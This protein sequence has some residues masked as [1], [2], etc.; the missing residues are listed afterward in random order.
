MTRLKF[1]TRGLLHGLAL[2]S[3]MIANEARAASYTFSTSLSGSIQDNSDCSDA[4]L[5]LRTF[6]V[7]DSFTVDDLNVGVVVD[8]TY[9][10]DLLVSLESPLGTRVPLV[11]GV[12]ANAQDL[13]VRLDDEA[14]SPLGTTDHDA[15]ATYPNVTRRPVN[16]LSSFDGEQAN[17]TW[18]M[19][20]CDQAPSDTG[21]FFAG[22]L[23]FDG[24]ASGGGGGPNGGADADY[25]YENTTVSTLDETVASCSGTPLTRNF[26]V[27]SFNVAD[28]DVGINITHSYRGD[29]TAT[30]TSPTGTKVDFLANDGGS[31]SNFDVLLDDDSAVVPGTGPYNIAAPYYDVTEAPAN[32]LSAFI[33]E[34]ALGTWTVEVCD[35]F[36]GDGGTL[37]RVQLSFMEETADPLIVT[38]TA[39]TDTLGTL[40]F[41]INH[42][43]ANAGD[44]NITF[45][46]TGGPRNCPSSP[47]PASASTALPRAG[48]L[49]AS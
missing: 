35:G 5:V 23:E 34:S 10:G 43:N 42:A 17:G 16:S 40:R 49:V 28:L 3:T 29:I 38:S 25:V 13:N 37:N 27:S 2:C 21:T 8:H 18:T 32:P 9:R 39:D 7:T 46:I 33:G 48:H 12:G 41:A 26:S 22:Y 14:A 44:D 47:M 6:N 4:N 30:V 1:L 24:T 31:D 45:N 15:L 19:R 20:V 36:N 11:L